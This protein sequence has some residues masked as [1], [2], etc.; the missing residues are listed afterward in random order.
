MSMSHRSYLIYHLKSESHTWAV[1]ACRQ[2]WS[3]SVTHLKRGAPG[4][5]YSPIISQ[6]PGWLHLAPAKAFFLTLELGRGQP[7][8]SPLWSVPSLSFLMT[9]SLWLSKSH[10]Y[11]SLVP[12]T[13]GPIQQGP[14]L[15]YSPL[16]LGGELDAKPHST[17]M[18]NTALHIC[19]CSP[20]CLPWDLPGHAH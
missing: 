1:L 4:W 5:Q 16:P 17:G 15:P 7:L 14:A 18:T 11:I 19:C 6:S 20:P 12:Y 10:S 8:A 9:L 3:S 13:S 2:T